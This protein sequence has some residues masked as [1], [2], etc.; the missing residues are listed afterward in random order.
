VGGSRELVGSL[1]RAP[2]LEVWPV[3]ASDD[4]SHAGDTVNR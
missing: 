1:L 2:G 3:E 4:L